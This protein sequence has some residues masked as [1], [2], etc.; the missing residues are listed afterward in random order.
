MAKKGSSIFGMK[1]NNTRVVPVTLKI[2]LIFTLFILFSNLFTNY[3]NLSFNRMELIS[4]AK[5]ILAKDLKEIHEFANTQYDIYLMNGEYESS[6][7]AIEEKAENQ[8]NYDKSIAF[9]MK[10]NGSFI[11]E[12][13]DGDKMGGLTDEKQIEKITGDETGLSRQF[14]VIEYNGED[15]LCVVSYN[16]KWDCYVVRG[17]ELTEFYSPTRA[18]FFKLS[19]IILGITVLLAIAGTL[20]LRYMLRFV[21]KFTRAI[22]DMINNSEMT[23]IDLDGATNDDVTFLGASFNSLSATI[24][25]LITIFRKFA[26]RDVAERAYKEKNIQL[27]GHTRE[28]TILF[29]DIKGFT[30]ITETLGPD[31]IKLLNMHYDKAI[32]AIF[33]EEGIIGSIIGDAI[34][35]VFG[36][37]NSLANKSMASVRAAYKLQRVAS[38]VR[39]EMNRIKEKIIEKQ[40]SLSEA[41]EKVHKAVLLQI[42]VGIDG[43]DVFYGNIGSRERMTNT[44]IGDNVN[45]SSRLEGLT[46]VYKTPVICSQYIKDD[47]ENNVADHGI[48][49]L[50]IDTVQVKGKTIGKVVY[51]PIL[52]ENL[53]EEM[54]QNINDFSKGLELYYDGK[55]PQ[56]RTFFNKCTLPLAEV[57][58]ERTSGICPADWKGIWTMKTK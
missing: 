28:L 34:L 43:G 40:G 19:F 7:E 6:I 46:R 4:L 2:A 55:W 18:I 24:D 29:S 47:I 45:S 23:L 44:V 22:M 15:Y 1:I 16:T 27:E 58:R 14:P 35:A 25:N 20:V 50:E 30:F 49:F 33:E 51:W 10:E 37:K 9:G 42:G 13:F 38:W 53:D 54:L 5:E 8:F 41:Q 32:G 3:I 39:T 21:N 56:A 36:T 57:F 11:F 31:I 48:H 12:A 17:E 52:K 26:T